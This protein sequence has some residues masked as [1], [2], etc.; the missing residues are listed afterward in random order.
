MMMAVT[1][2][3]NEKL[4][5]T[6]KLRSSRDIRRY[7]LFLME[8]PRFVTDRLEAG[9]VPLW[10]I[11]SEEA[12]KN[13]VITASEVEAAGGEVL[14]IPREIFGGLADTETSQGL[15]AVFRL[16][17]LR[18]RPGR[19]VLI[20][21]GVSDPGNVG[22]LIRSAAAFGCGG[23]VTGKN[24]AFPFAPKVTRASAG[25]NAALPIEYD[26]DLPA[27]VRENGLNLEF[28]G[29]DPKGDDPE[30][31]NGLERPPG[32]VVGSEA[33]GISREVGSLF[34]RRVAI[35]MAPGVESLNAAVSGSILLFYVYRSSRN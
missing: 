5:I 9:T 17:E 8:G 21:D 14:V 1:S 4:K 25:L 20:L 23:V 24:T 15:M 6:R 27:M 28:V 29:M 34:D 7:G 30:T 2:R 33:R 31:L 19:T 11:L 18:I 32:I 22:T 26:V 16:P 12:G 3:S 13:A 35:P 10:T